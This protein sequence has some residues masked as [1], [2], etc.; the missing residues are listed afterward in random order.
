[1]ATFRI[2][3]SRRWADESIP[4]VLVLKAEG[5]SQSESGMTAAGA[6]ARFR[7][8]VSQWLANTKEGKA[9]WEY[10]HHDFNYGDFRLAEEDPSF[11]RFLE[12][13]GLTSANVERMEAEDLGEEWDSTFMPEDAS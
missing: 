3:V 12:A 10:S 5:T 11:L 13:N 8:S 2:D 1:M 6:L 4:A 9:A 7:R